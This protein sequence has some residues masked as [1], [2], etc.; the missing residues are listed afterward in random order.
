[1][2]YFQACCGLL[3]ATEMADKEKGD[4]LE[5]DELNIQKPLSASMKQGHVFGALFVSL[6][7]IALFGDF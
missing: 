4:V 6:I 7:A 2:Y 3:F 5:V 1:M